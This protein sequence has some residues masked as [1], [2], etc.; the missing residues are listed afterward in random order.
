MNE[1]GIELHSIDIMSAFTLIAFSKR[2]RTGIMGL[3]AVRMRRVEIRPRWLAMASGHR[4]VL[5]HLF[6][7]KFAALTWEAISAASNLCYSKLVAGGLEP[8]R[9]SRHR[10]TCH[11]LPHPGDLYAESV[12]T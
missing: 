8:T 3:S 11:M 10:T 9:N 2:R 4:Q 7:D 6:F 12:Q 5:A 1:Y